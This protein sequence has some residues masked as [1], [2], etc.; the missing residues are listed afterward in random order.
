MAPELWQRN[1]GNRTHD[2]VVVF[3]LGVALYYWHTEQFPFIN[4]DLDDEF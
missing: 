3:S 2:K 4:S 1:T